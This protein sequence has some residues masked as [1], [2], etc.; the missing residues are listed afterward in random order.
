MKENKVRCRLLISPFTVISQGYSDFILSHIDH[1]VW[2]SLYEMYM[3]TSQMEKQVLLT[4]KFFIPS[5][6]Q[7]YTAV[8]SHDDL[9]IC[10][11]LILCTW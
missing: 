5:F 2:L 9:R 6:S 4:Y 1:S 3:L 11:L 10:T 8:Y 7:V